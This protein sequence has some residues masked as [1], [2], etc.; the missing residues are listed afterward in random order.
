[1]TGLPVVLV[2][3]GGDRATGGDLFLSEV[4]RRTGTIIIRPP[5]SLL[6][7]CYL[8]ANARAMVS[9]RFHPSIMASL[10]GTP[11]TFLECSAHKT[12]SLQHQLEYA[13]PTLFPMDPAPGNLTAVLRHLEEQLAGGQRLRDRIRGVSAHLGAQVRQGIGDTMEALH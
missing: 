10:G 5:V 6:M 9:G 4:A 3:S 11:C 2:D 12:L 8:V 1:V 13:H 7:A